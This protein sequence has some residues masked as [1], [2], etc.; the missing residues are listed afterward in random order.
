MAPF[1]LMV[2][3]WISPGVVFLNGAL[4]LGFLT[5][6]PVNWWLIKMGIKEPI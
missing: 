4:I 6:Y 5:A 2:I 1:W 3:S